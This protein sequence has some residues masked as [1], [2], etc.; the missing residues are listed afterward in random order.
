M[1]VKLIQTSLEGG[2]GAG[3]TTLGD[4][5]GSLL[6]A[7]IGGAA[8]GISGGGAEPQISMNFAGVTHAAG[9]GSFGAGDWG[10]V[11]EQGPELVRFGRAAQVYPSGTAGAGNV[12]YIDARGADAAAVARMEKALQVMNYSFEH[13][14]LAAVS[15]ERKRG[16]A[17][18]AAFN[19]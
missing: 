15:N 2:G 16:G 17:F 14:A 4:I 6:G 7:V 12:A 11:G 3:G 9:G 8:G 13:R 10:I 18:A 1:V 19:R 5:F